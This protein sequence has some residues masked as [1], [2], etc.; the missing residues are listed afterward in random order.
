M[1][2]T[3]ISDNN[4]DISMYTTIYI[5]VVLFII[6]DFEIQSK[7]LDDLIQRIVPPIE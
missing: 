4:G 3:D 2:L 7:Y 1:K 6:T 5:Y